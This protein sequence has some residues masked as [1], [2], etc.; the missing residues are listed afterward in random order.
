MLVLMFIASTKE[1]IVDRFKTT[2]HIGVFLLAFG[3]ANPLK[4]SVFVFLFS[5]FFRGRAVN[6]FINS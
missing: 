2:L 1:Y 6:V 5:S 4:P 3:L